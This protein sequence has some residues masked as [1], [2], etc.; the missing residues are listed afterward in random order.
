M[1]VGRRNRVAVQ[2]KKLTVA[3]GGCEELAGGLTRAFV[4]FSRGTNDD[5]DDDHN[6][7]TRI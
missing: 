7:R 5:Y 2:R 4:A 1:L 3:T 6:D